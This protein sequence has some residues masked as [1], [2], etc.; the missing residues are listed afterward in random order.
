MGWI[1]TSENCW[2][3][4]ESNTTTTQSIFNNNSMEDKVIFLLD[5]ERY[6]DQDVQGLTRK[7]LEKWIAEEDYNDDYTIMKIDANAYNSVSEAI[8]EEIG[9]IA[10]CDVHEIYHVFAFGIK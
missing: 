10:P 4:H 1:M 3:L 6:T 5:K 2:Q 7:D 8:E 9:F